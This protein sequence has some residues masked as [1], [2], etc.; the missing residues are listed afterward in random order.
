MFKNLLII[1]CCVVFSSCS[2]I[3]GVGT[4]ESELKLMSFNIRYDNQ[5]DNDNWWGHRKD[6]LAKFVIRENAD[7]IGF[8]EVLLQQLNF[9]KSN[10]S[11]YEYV[12]VGRDDGKVNGEFIPVFYK[13]DRFKLIKNDTFWFSETPTVPG[14]TTWQGIPRICTW[15]ELKDKVSGKSLRIYNIHLD[16]ASQTSREESAVMLNDKLK[17]SDFFGVNIVL[18]DFNSAEQ[19]PVTRFLKGD[20]SLNEQTVAIKLVDSFRTLYPDEK[21]VGTGNR[22]KDR[23]VG[24]KIDHIF[25]P[26]HMT[27]KSAEIVREKRT[28]S[29]N[30]SD[31]FPVTAVLEF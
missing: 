19:N 29:L 4:T 24:E 20:L 13:K 9:L 21:M 12:G 11:A 10:M 1:C 17:N 27:V 16:H 2:L 31:H 23:K 25:V 7:I 18:G 26:A 5:N 22:F 30:L 28:N 14:S 6:E 15:V 3:N 8:Q